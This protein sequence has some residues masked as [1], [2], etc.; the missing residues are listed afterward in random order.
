MPPVLFPDDGARPMV[1]TQSRER[2]VGSA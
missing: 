2:L 1:Q